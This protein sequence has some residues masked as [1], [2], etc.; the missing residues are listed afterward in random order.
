MEISQYNGS[1]QWSQATWS[2]TSQDLAEESEI[3]PL[4]PNLKSSSTLLKVPPN[5]RVIRD[6]VFHISEAIIWTAKEF[7]D[8]CGSMD[9]FWVLNSTREIKNGRQM[10]NYWCRLWRY[11]AIKTQGSGH[12]TKGIR[13]IEACEMKL[14]IYK[15]WDEKNHLVSVELLRNELKSHGRKDG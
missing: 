6:Q 15:L 1:D 4:L 2:Q 14:N 11:A 12:R 10:L 5:I 9:N 13:T 7:H 3:P 8:Y